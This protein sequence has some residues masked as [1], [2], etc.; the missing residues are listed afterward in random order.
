MEDQLYALLQKL[1]IKNNIN[2]SREELKLQVLTHPSYPSLHA[3]KGVLNHFNIPNLALRVPINEEVFSQLP[4]CFLAMVNYEGESLVL[5][6]K[7]KGTV[8]ITFQNKKKTSFTIAQFLSS[9]NGI[10]IAIEKDE[11]ILEEK[12]NYTTALHWGGVLLVVFGGLFLLKDLSI[13]GLAFIVLSLIGLLVSYFIIKQDLGL[14]NSAT[15]RLCNLSEQVSCNAVLQSP[16][17]K[18]FGVFKLSDSSV[19]YF[20]SILIFAIVAQLSYLPATGVFSLTSILSLPV[21][22]YSI[23]YQKL[24]VKKWC[25]LCL[26]I[27]G[28]LALQAVLVFTLK[29]YDEILALDFKTIGLFLLATLIVS[30]L[31]KTVIDFAK[32]KIALK[33]IKVEHL[34]FKNNFTLFNAIYQQNGRLNTSYPIPGEIVLGNKNAPVELVLVT[35]PFCSY[36]K[37]AHRDIEQ[38]LQ[39]S[40]N[41]VKIIVRFI[42]D[43]SKKESDLYK[44]V[45]QLLYLYHTQGEAKTIMAL[46][47][48]YGPASN[49]KQW[50]ENQTITYNDVY[51]KTM[52]LQKQWATE[53]GINFTPALYLNDRQFPKEYNRTDIV[54]FLEDFIENYAQEKEA[55]VSMIHT[56]VA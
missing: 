41:R 12:K 37:Q 34:K 18:I 38:I 30:S 31:V 23:Y 50:I 56:S 17:A 29:G 44:L 11:T 35:S 42:V 22:I 33:T 20:S 49:P 36:C 39:T 52:E 15:H 27:G 46:D 24:V 48:L 51:N 5:V 16:G 43:P 2:L 53:N 55:K 1:I 32:D 8:N 3:V 54:P 47:L 14:Q 7:Q 28:V 25:P 13:L 4:K 19:I 6:E 45:S 21:L 40:K 10:V 9:W 26:G